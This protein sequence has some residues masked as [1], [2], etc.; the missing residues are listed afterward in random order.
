M[1]VHHQRALR[2]GKLIAL[3]AVMTGAGVAALAAQAPAPAPAPK[4]L[5]LPVAAQP[6]APAPQSS[7][8]ATPDVRVQ[9]VADTI[10]TIGAPMSGRLTQFPLH[11]GD[12]FKQGQTLARFDC[13]EKEAA[14]AH[15]RAVLESRK[16]VNESKQ[17]LRALGTSSQVEYEVAAADEK[18][19]AA[20][21]QAAQTL[22]ENCSVTAPFSGRVSAIY[23]H[24]YQYLQTGA[25]L[26]E[27]LSDKS[28]E[29][30][31]IVPSMWLSW[32]KPGSPLKVSIDETGKTYPATLSRLS[33]K[34]DPV[35]RSVKVYAHIDNPSDTLLPGMSGH[36]AFSPPAGVALTSRQ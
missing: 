30:E 31:M 11:D 27:I 6:H 22:V 3:V 34:V 5:P 25:P 23:S 7:S 4:A 33:G 10:A 1:K 32:L 9:L 21:V 12:R 13:G 20:D 29:L 15:T 36:A 28:L 16:S 14:L 18:Q 17:R 19:A 2:A 35:S 24:N 8:S 26:L